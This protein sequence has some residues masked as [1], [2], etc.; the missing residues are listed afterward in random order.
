MVLNAI[1]ICKSLNFS[2]RKQTTNIHR[3][4]LLTGGGPP[5]AED[6]DPVLHLI[7]TTLPGVDVELI[8]PYDSIAT[9]ENSKH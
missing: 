8:N 7:K 1:Y 2:C 3:N 5:A 6:D 9:F 4:R